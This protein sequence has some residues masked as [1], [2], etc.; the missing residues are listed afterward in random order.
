VSSGSTAVFGNAQTVKH[1][2]GT[3]QYRIDFGRALAG[4]I[5]SATLAA[6]QAGP[7]L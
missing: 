2:S 4:C 5:Y 1:L 3:N 6:V 7:V